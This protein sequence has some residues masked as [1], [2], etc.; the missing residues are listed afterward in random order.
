MTPVRVAVERN[1][2][3]VMVLS[4]TFYPTDRTSEKPKG[5]DIEG[6]IND[7]APAK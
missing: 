4:K 5:I 1:T 6:H 3:S 7:E 2:R